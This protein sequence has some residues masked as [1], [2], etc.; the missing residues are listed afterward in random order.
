L[1]RYLIEKRGGILFFIVIVNQLGGVSEGKMFI[2]ITMAL[3][4]GFKSI[5]FVFFKKPTFLL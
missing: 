4:A 2:G 5:V 3:G 1:S